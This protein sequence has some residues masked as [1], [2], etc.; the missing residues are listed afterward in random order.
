M[1][2]LHHEVARKRLAVGAAV[3]VSVRLDH[4]SDPHPIAAPSVRASTPS[5]PSSGTSSW[6]FPKPG[7]PER[8]R[9]ATTSEPWPKRA[10][11]S[12]VS[13]PRRCPP[14]LAEAP[15][16]TITGWENVVAA[17]TEVLKRVRSLHHDVVNVWEQNDGV[18]IYESVGA[19]NLFDGTVISINACTVLT[20][21]DGKFAD[22]R[23][24]VDNAPVL[25]ALG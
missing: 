4:A 9:Q 20:L 22:Q 14:G 6:T 25:A 5:S 10:Q 1:R 3:P 8:G 16:P 17:F 24:Y 23:I 19:W 13:S 15:H 2:R 7:S 18:V 12:R 11:T 21:V